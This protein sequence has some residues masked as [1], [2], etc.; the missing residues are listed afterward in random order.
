MVVVVLTDPPMWTPDQNPSGCF[1]FFGSG[2]A[3]AAGPGQACGAARVPE[4]PVEPGLQFWARASPLQAPANSGTAS[5][6]EDLRARAVGMPA[7]Q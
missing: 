6:R 3:L 1:T 4:T 2:F 7:K 5:K